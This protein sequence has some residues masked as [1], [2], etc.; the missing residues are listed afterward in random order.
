[1]ARRLTLRHAGKVFLDRWG[2]E[3]RWFGVFLHH[4]AGPDPGLDLHDHPWP[5]VS[6]IL[7]G[8]YTE[9][10]ADARQACLMAEIAERYPETATHGGV[11]AWRRGSVHRLGLDEAHRITKV[12]PGTWTLVLRGRKVRSWGFYQPD[13]WVN[14]QSYDYAT[15]RPNDVASSNPEERMTERHAAKVGDGNAT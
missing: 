15:R 9:E 1:M 5:F 6:V 14:W 10:V 4:I 7:R 3:T 13:G 2:L 12:E 11:R 8:S